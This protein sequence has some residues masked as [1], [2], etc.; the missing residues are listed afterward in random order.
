MLKMI[1]VEY[2]LP[3]IV[4]RA[5]MRH[6]ASPSLIEFIPL[7][8]TNVAIILHVQLPLVLCIS[9]FT[10]RIHDD[11][12][13]A[14]QEQNLYNDEEEEVICYAHEINIPVCSRI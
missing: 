1:N 5:Y 14:V 7:D 11:T 2:I 8:I 13:K 3:Q 9:H 4:L 12:Q 10:E 6:K